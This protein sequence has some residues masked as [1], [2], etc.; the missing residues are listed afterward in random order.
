[1]SVSNMA[2]AVTLLAVMRKVGLIVRLDAGQLRVGPAR[3]MEAYDV[4][5]IKDH[6]GALT[7]I[8]AA[9]SAPPVESA[10]EPSVRPEQDMAHC[11]AC[12]HFLPDAINPAQGVGHCGVT[13]A[14]PP[15]A[16]SEDHAAC[17]PL[18]PRQCPSYERN[19]T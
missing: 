13:G 1:M 7:S 15:S 8:L 2:E 12:S 19:E 11:G 18:A 14:G 4:A 9:E 17:Y 16:T 5:Y 6:R 10:A 3:L